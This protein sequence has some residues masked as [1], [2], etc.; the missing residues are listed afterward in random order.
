M[1]KVIETTLPRSSQLTDRI[2]Q[3][4]FVDCYAVES[5]LSPRQAANIIT[6]FPDWARFLVKIRN[7]I[8]SKFGLSS[9]T[10]TGPDKT[11]FFPIESETDQELIAGFND[12]HLD[13][14]IS[15]ISKDSRVF[16][17]TWV[18]PHN[19][20]GRIY[21][22]TILPFHILIVRNALTRVHAMNHE[23]KTDSLG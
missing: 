5:Q 21:L 6:D 14:R 13:F 12:K 8:V 17:S 23:I 19:I 7:T 10:S 22:N 9:D 20:G 11:G 15:V 2:Q 18:H 4:D 16:L 3:S 1:D